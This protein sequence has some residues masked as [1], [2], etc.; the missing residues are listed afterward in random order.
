MYYQINYK[1]IE[2]LDYYSSMPPPGL[3]SEKNRNKKYL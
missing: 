1:I 2:M 3:I